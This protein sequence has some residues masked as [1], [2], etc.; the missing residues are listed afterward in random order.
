M[1]STFRTR[2]SSRPGPRHCCQTRVCVSAAD[3]SSVTVS[4]WVKGKKV[5]ADFLHWTSVLTMSRTLRFSV[6]VVET[7]SFT[8]TAYYTV[9][10][11]LGRAGPLNVLHSTVVLRSSLQVSFKRPKRCSRTKVKKRKGLFVKQ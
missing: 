1:H 5:L 3:V 11:S 6:G 2:F 4:V 10:P 9:L 7:R 8:E